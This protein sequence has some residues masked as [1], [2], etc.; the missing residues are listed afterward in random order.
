AYGVKP[1]DRGWL[2][3][4]LDRLV[5]GA[6][7]PLRVLSVDDEE[8]ARYI[9]RQF[10]DGTEYEVIEAASGSEGLQKARRESPD[11]ILLDPRLP[12]TTGFD[13][14]DRL[15]VDHATAMIPVLV[16]TSKRLSEEDRK[17]LTPA[18]A[19]LSKSS[20]T[21]ETLQVAVARAVRERGVVQ[22]AS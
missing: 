10:L 21:R 12:D 3:A 8:A 19:F 16:V 7:A 9:I 17:R 5:G 20:L 13:V 1:V 2:V 18:T 22:N 6:R 4:T 11:V 15:R 14:F